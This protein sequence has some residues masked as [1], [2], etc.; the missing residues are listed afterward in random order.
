MPSDR[1]HLD[2]RADKQ[3]AAREQ[4]F[5]DADRF[6]AEE[7]ALRPVSPPPA[8]DGRAP[9]REERMAAIRSLAE[10][11]RRHEGVTLAFDLAT[12]KPV[13]EDQRALFGDWLKFVSAISIDETIALLDEVAQSRAAAPPADLAAL[14]DTYAREIA[15]AGFGYVTDPSAARAALDRALA[16]LVARVEANVESVAHAIYDAMRENDPEGQSHP[17]VERGNSLKQDEARQRARAA[18]A[19]GTCPNPNCVGGFVGSV[20]CAVCKSAALPSGTS[21]YREAER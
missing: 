5:A 2:A 14:V 18:L 7:K 8:E 13:P 6:Y 16:A 4:R 11:V 1:T 12:T 10:Q 17:W 3:L 9:M 20:G 15:D 19:S 21:T